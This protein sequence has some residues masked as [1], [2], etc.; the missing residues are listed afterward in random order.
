MEV[1]ADIAR[2]MENLHAVRAH[3]VTIAGW[4]PRRDIEAA[5]V[6]VAIFCTDDLSVSGG[7]DGRRAVVH[8]RES[9]LELVIGTVMTVITCGKS[10]AIVGFTV[11]CIHAAW[12]GYRVVVHA[13]GDVK[14][15]LSFE[16]WKAQ[17]Q[18]AH[19]NFRGILLDGGTGAEEQGEPARLEKGTIFGQ[20][21]GNLG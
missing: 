10:T 13:H 20:H 6:V 21:T 4:F 17:L 12:V 1:G 5:A 16:N 19:L 9:T 11:D 8:R 15:A 18:S 7:D 14:D 3:R 2:L